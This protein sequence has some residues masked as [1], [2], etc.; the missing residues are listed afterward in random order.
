MSN[1]K[2]K[3]TILSH[4]LSHN[5]LGRAH[6]IATALSRYYNVEI[7]GPSVN[8]KIWA[9]LKDDRT[10]AIKIF[11]SNFLKN[12]R[13]IDGD[14][15][16]AIKPKGKSFGYALVKNK[17][18]KSKRPI[19]LD[20]D[21][22]E[23]GEFLDMPKY[24]KILKFTFSL[25]RFW[26][27][28]NILTTS[29]L[30]TYTHKATMITV[31]NY[32]LKQ[33]YG[34]KLIPH[35]RNTAQFDP[36]N[37]NQDNIKKSY[38]LSNKD[39]ILF[40]GTP[41]KHKGILDLVNSIDSL[42]RKDLVLMLVGVDK[43]FQHSIPKKSFIK[44][45]GQQPFDNIPKFLAMADIV[46]IFQSDSLSS[47]GQLPAKVFD[48]MAMS[49]PI[50]ASRVSDLPKVLSGCG[51]VVNPGD[52]KVLSNKINYLLDNPKYAHELGRKARLKCIKEYSYDAISPKLYNVVEAVLV[53]ERPTA[54]T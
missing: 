14:I 6:I 20:I 43:G 48:A 39:I 12:L 18:S 17:I 16:Y 26:N 47:R 13:D 33:R 38:G 10:V 24:K 8:G 45:F 54:I 34:G 42:N 50:I 49:K 4:D 52:I 51:E 7:V 5:C 1:S 23:L 11:G 22:F 53:K 28:N 46:T 37:Y 3:I 15:L 32:F 40:L 44:T 41:R 31:S 30:E 35:F 2:I 19:I 27:I 21:D 29:I 36:L 25:I 9:P